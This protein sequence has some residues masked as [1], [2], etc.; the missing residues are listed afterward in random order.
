MTPFYVYLCNDSVTTEIYTYL[1]TL[2]LHD[3]RPIC[4]NRRRVVGS[5]CAG[6]R[7]ALCDLD[8]LRPLDRRGACQFHGTPAL[9]AAVAPGCSC[10]HG[11]LVPP[12][13]PRGPGGRLRGAP[14][15]GWRE[16]SLRSRPTRVPRP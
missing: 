13:R 12:P 1:H 14:W 5:G 4:C 11:R 15:P 16:P 3:A 2:S 7:A 9:V 8:S 6:L 10:R